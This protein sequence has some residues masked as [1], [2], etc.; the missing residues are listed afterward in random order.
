MP[1]A[2]GVA[3]AIVCKEGTTVGAILARLGE[4]AETAL[5]EGRIFVGSRRA[6]GSS[7]PVRAGDEV[8]MHPARA[9]A[10][11]SARVLLERGGIVA[12]YKPAAMPTVADHRGA[13]G[14]LEQELTRMVGAARPLVPTSRLDVGVSGV[15]LFAADDEARKNLARAR[16]EGRYRRH[17]MAIVRGA[18]ATPRGIWSGP[19][20]R[21][22]DPRRR[23][24]GG[25]DAVAAETAY[26]V[27]ASTRVASLLAV[28]PRTGRTHQIRV[29]AM[30][31]GCPLYGDEAYGGPLRV[32]SGSGAVRAIARIAL[33]AAWVEVALGAEILRVGAEIPEELAAI[34]IECGGE[35]GDWER[36]ERAL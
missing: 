8:V 35:E 30:S 26:A 14:T 12:A 18:P 10:P 7:D 17:Y 29:H 3:V 21:D 2:D 11:E 4:G 27:V 19:I 22:R 36:A 6:L 33:H 32:V 31:A 34:W 13:T 25:R 24:V 5:R 16:E 1:R 9:S 20:G 28:E 23:R 15:V